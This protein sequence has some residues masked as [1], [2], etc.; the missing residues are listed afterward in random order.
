LTVRT[1]PSEPLTDREIDMVRQVAQG[2]TNSEIAADLY[3]P[4]A[5]V[6]TNLANVQRKLAVRNRVEIAAWAW[7]PGWC[8]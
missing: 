3:V 4:Q 7:R 8:F 1:G 5:T 2:R 6:K